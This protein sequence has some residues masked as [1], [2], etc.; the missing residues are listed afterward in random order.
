[1]HGPYTTIKWMP[2]DVHPMMLNIFTDYEAAK[3]QYLT[4]TF[5]VREGHEPR[6]RDWRASVAARLAV[7]ASTTFQAVPVYRDAQ[8]VKTM[9]RSMQVLEKGESIIVWPDVEYRAGYDKPCS[10]YQGF[11]FLG[12][13]YWR[14]TGKTL[15][16][17]PLYID[18]AGRRLIARE[19]VTLTNYKQQAEEV[20]VKL[21]KAIDAPEPQA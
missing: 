7:L 21:A 20:A 17:V 19:P 8:A 5:S 11:L 18:D 2:F 15:Q 9:R 3:K 6:K 10:I 16:F 13:L 12:E 1:M 4:Y 14:K